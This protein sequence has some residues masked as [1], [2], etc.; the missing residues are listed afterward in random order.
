MKTIE[1]EF[2]DGKSTWL[3][4]DGDLDY[5]VENDC[6]YATGVKGSRFIVPLVNTKLISIKE[7]GE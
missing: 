3:N 5:G 7:A 1:I 4:V 6:L 2:A